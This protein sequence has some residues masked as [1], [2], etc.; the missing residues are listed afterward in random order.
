MTAHET[1]TPGARPLGEWI[2][3]PALLVPPPMLIPYLAVAGR[4][5]LFSGREKIGKSTLV[6]GAVAA[7]SRGL[8]VLGVPVSQPIR[9]LWYSI[10]E[11]FGDTIRRFQA[12]GADLNNVIVSK[13]PS[14]AEQL[15]LEIEA[16]VPTYPVHLVVV[17]NLSRIFTA[18]RLDSNQGKDVGPLMVKLVNYFHE[19][20]L[21]AVLLYHTGKGGREYV[22]SVQIGAAVDEKLTMRKR[23]QSTDEDDFDDDT[24]DD[25]RRLLEQ[26]GRNLRGRVQLQCVDGIY[27]L[28]DDARPMRA[29]ILETLH[30]AGTVESRT[31]L[32]GLVGGRKQKALETIA[33]LIAYHAITETGRRLTLAPL[34]LSEL[35]APVPETVGS[36]GTTGTDADATN[37]SHRF[38]P[39]GTA[40]EPTREP[41]DDLVAPCSQ[42]ELDLLAKLERERAA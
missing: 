11:P 31:K 24:P 16:D 29:K 41:G 20:E 3:D 32:A 12:L 5:S 39:L 7:A 2:A 26:D 13:E 6:A 35:M 18:G 22:G 10:D 27:R 8:N 30:N 1:P 37:G 23:G 15:L 4:V 28:Y 9:T 36:S 25:G 21:A 33:D 14:N 17:D 40:P 19:T 42:A 34:G 38:P